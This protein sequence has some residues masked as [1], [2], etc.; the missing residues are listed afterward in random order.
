LLPVFCEKARLA[1]IMK[2]T[3]KIF[4]IRFNFVNSL[5]GYLS[6]TWVLRLLS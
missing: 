3:M 1:L 4:F 6:H 2:I 5:A